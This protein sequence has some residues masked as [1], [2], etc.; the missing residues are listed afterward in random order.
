M[1]R[2]RS[3]LALVFATMACGEAT[4]PLDP[5]TYVGQYTLTTVN[6]LTAPQTVA[7]SPQGCSA[8]FRYGSLTLANDV[9]ALDLFGVWGACP[10]VY[11]VLGNRTIGGGLEVDQRTLLLRAV[12]PTSPS[13]TVMRFEGRS[14]GSEVELSFPPGA[15]KLADTTTLGFRR[16]VP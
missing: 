1:N 10:G 11:A 9:F 3:T 13:G 12:D 7:T 8:T 2:L 14:S 15:M 5:Q 6:G 4:T 16:T